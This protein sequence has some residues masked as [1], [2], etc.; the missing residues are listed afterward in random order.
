M[1]SFDVSDVLNGAAVKGAEID[2]EHALKFL[3]SYNGST[4][5]FNAYRRELER[6]LQWS[7][8]VERRNAHGLARE[9]IEDFVRFSL[10]PPP[11]WIGEIHAPRF[12][13]D[14]GERKPNPKWRPFV[15][16]LSENRGEKRPQTRP[17]GNTGQASPLFVQRS[18][19]CRHSMIT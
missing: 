4:A 10:S 17:K 1:K 15:A 9:D 19:R 2:Y 11:A 8:R 18:R 3:Y 16:S 5:T 6:L 14:K 13:M 12:V 7:W